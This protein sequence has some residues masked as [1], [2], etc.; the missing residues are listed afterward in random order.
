MKIKEFVTKPRRTPVYIGRYNGAVYLCSKCHEKMKICDLSGEPLQKYGFGTNDVLFKCGCSNQFLMNCSEEHAEKL[1]KEHPEFQKLY[2]AG[3]VEVGSPMITKKL[4]TYNEETGVLSYSESGSEVMAYRIKMCTPEGREL[5]FGG[6]PE[7]KANIIRHGIINRVSLNFRTGSF[8]GYQKEPQKNAMKKGNLTDMNGQFYFYDVSMAIDFIKEA[9]KRSGLPIAV[10]VSKRDVATDWMRDTVYYR[11]GDVEVTT[12]GIVESIAFILNVIAN[13]NVFIRYDG[14]TGK[15][16]FRKICDWTRENTQGYGLSL[17]GV[18]E[19]INVY[20]PTSKEFRRIHPMKL[21]D[22]G[23]YIQ[24][25]VD[26]LKV[27][28]SRQFMKL[29]RTNPLSVGLVHLLMQAGFEK[30]DNIRKLI[31]TVGN[32]SYFP[33]ALTE[34]S[35]RFLKALVSNVGETAAANK[36]TRTCFTIL[37][38]AWKMYR[39]I[40]KAGL[41]EQISF[42]GDVDCIHDELVRIFNEVGLDNH[43]ITYTPQ[44][45]KRVYETDRYAIRLAEDTHRLLDIGKKMHICVGSYDQFALKKQCTIY[46]IAEKQTDRYVGCIE[47]RDNRLIQAKGYCNG[48]LQNEKNLLVQWTQAKKINTRSCCDYEA[49][50]A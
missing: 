3:K 36:C 12:L 7:F 44:E 33:R 25:L 48:Y 5:E 28:S 21:M 37:N 47:M 19:M 32:E 42:S 29:Y 27:P 11:C 10:R 39:A 16:N 38:D 6:E 17:F 30:P 49:I 22:E 46:Y 40:K 14:F 4:L 35:F 18:E 50:V 1:A 9:I 15:V 26:T 43:E 13:P 41:E 23:E 24:L 31:T 45:E 34:T 20:L 2:N 8:Y